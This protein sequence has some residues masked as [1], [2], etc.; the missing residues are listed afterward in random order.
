MGS[1]TYIWVSARDILLFAFVSSFLQKLRKGDREKKKVS[2]QDDELGTFFYLVTSALLL[3][4][5]TNSIY[6][7]TLQ[8]K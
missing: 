5:I 3:N 2:V 8:G 4:A 1:T 7:K 6:G